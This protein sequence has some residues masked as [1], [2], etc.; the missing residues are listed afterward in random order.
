VIAEPEKPAAVPT[1]VAP[2]L[3]VP[4]L[5]PPLVEVSDDPSSSLSLDR[6]PRSVGEVEPVIPEPLGAGAWLGLGTGLL[7]SGGIITALR[8]RFR[9]AGV[10]RGETAE[11]ID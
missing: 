8:R 10:A 5:I 9:R 11:G 4:A 6:V 1:P 3:E 7:G 2:T